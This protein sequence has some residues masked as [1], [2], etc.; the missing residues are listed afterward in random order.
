MKSKLNL[1]LFEL[2]LVN[3]CENCEFVMKSIEEEFGDDEIFFTTNKKDIW[4]GLQF[5]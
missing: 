2:K 1:R 5:P 3:Y 4:Q